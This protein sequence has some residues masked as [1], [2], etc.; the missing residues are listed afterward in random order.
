[1]SIYQLP[2]IADTCDVLVTPPQKKI[3]I[4]LEN[5]VGEQ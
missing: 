5:K 2:T 4:L 3:L 1:M